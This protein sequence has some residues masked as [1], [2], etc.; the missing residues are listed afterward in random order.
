MFVFDLQTGEWFTPVICR[1]MYQ[2][3]IGSEAVLVDQTSD[4]VFLYNGIKGSCSQELAEL[5]LFGNKWQWTD[6]RTPRIS[7][8]AE[9]L[10]V[11]L[12]NKDSVYHLSS[13]ATTGFKGHSAESRFIIDLW[14]LDL[15]T[16]QWIYLS[17]LNWEQGDDNGAVLHGDV[18]LF[19]HFTKFTQLRFV[20]GYIISENKLVEYEDNI[21]DD[22]V[23]PWRED[24]SLVA[25]NSTSLFLCGGIS[26]RLE[27]MGDSWILSLHSPESQT[28]EWENLTLAMSL[29]RDIIRFPLPC[30]IPA[31]CSCAGRYGLTFWRIRSLE[32]DMRS[33]CLE[34]LFG[35]K[36]MDFGLVCSRRI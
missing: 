34:S 26:N 30:T 7:L 9:I 19:T 15:T 35:R 23:P 18:L 12:M 21:T 8:P 11:A 24:Y 25:L 20:I 16:L 17:G 6:K 29:P 27:I 14:R 32:R 33:R 3:V 5:S 28:V 4:R 2:V 10:G 1:D 22:S 36:K 13:Y 31:Q